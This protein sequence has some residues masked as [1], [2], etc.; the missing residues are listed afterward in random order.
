MTRDLVHHLI[1]QAF[2]NPILAELDDS[3][4][5]PS[6][7]GRLAFTTDS[8]VVEPV[9]FRGGDIGKL[10]ICGTVNDLAMMGAV[11]KYLSVGFI[12]E[13]G[14]LLHD[15]KEILNSMKAAALEAGVAVIT[16]DTKVVGSGSADRIFINTSGLGLMP[17]GVRLSGAN[18]VPGDVVIINGPIGDHGIAV[19]DNR[20]GLGLGIPVESDCAPLNHLVGK[21][22]EVTHQIHVL[23]DPTRGGVASTLNEIAESSDV[24]IRLEESSI[25]V[26]DE[27]KA[28][29][30]LLGF[31]PLYVANEGKLVAIC[32]E[33]QA[34]PLLSVMRSDR[35]GREAVVIGKVVADPHHLVTLKTVLGGTRIVDMMV[36]DQLPRIC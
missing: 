35:Y 15:F 18:A 16:G 2:H 1:L 9:F 29:C 6:L 23:R 11:P 14:L 28:A 36:G 13:E 19:L 34:G 10:S 20:E 22:L 5:V 32:P 25:P 26:R 31:D 27:V 24:G 30:D 4:V 17:E 7:E 12:L 3:A 21:M 8:Y 33:E